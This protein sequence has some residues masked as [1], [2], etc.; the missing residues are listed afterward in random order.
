VQH[1][2]SGILYR[3]EFKSGLW[4]ASLG[5]VSGGEK[6]LAQAFGYRY[7]NRFMASASGGM[8]ASDKFFEGSAT[9]QP[10]RALSFSAGHR[11]FF[12]PIQASGDSVSLY[13]GLDRFDFQASLNDSV[14]Q[15]RR[16][17][18]QSIGAGVRVSVLSEQSN[19]YHSDSH[20]ILTHTIS[21]RFSRRLIL[22]EGVTR[23]ATGNSFNVG[24]SYSSN[25]WSVSL[26]RGVAF[27]LNGK[28][29]QATIASQR[30]SLTTRRRSRAAKALAQ[31]RKERGEVPGFMKARR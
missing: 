27:L 8:I 6:T 10:I 26:T 31:A 7:R 28:G 25:R 20:T 22:T 23:S 29:F 5:S 1:I 18:G 19:R 17:T 16:L 3:Q 30:D 15:G 2:A 11:S 12:H 13:A 4:M 24:G 21:E 9:F 14:S